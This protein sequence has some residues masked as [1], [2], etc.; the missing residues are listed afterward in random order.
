MIRSL[1]NGISGLRS[2]QTR[3]DV[4]SNNIANVNSIGFK[5]GR[6]T[7]VE[8][9]GQEMLGLGRTAGGSNINPGYIGQ[10]VSVGSVDQQW[11]QG[12]LQTTNFATD[13]ALHGDGFF[14]GSN[15]T[16]ELLT[17]D[18]H[19][20]FNEEGYLVTSGGIKIQ[21]W[22]IAE[23]GSVNMG[24]MQDVQINFDALAKPQETSNIS[25]GGNLAANTAIGEEITISTVLFDSQGERHSVLM[26]YTKTGT[27][28]WDVATELSDGTA[29]GTTAIEFDDEGNLINPDPPEL[30]LTGDYPDTTTPDDID[31]TI[32]LA[33]LKQYDGSTTAT[34]RSNDGRTTGDLLGYS[35]DPSGVLRVNF[36]NGD[37]TP[38]F[39]L[40]IGTVNN[41]N[42]L[43]QLGDNFYGVTDASGDLIAGRAGQ[44]IQTAIVA[45]ALEMS[46]VDLAE[47]F[48]DMII[49]QRGY[50]AS[51]RVITTSDEML[52]ETMQLKR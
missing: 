13:L 20:L 6:S 9:L 11:S 37:Q 10:G 34:V 51:A 14:I 4:I 24:K 29:L 41:P 31:V 42:G 17:R 45:G 25:I 40:A 44:E 50:Q 12:A 2:H 49:A 1:H 15:G 28:T 32:S 7:F 23:D 43:E 19:L 52:Q 22:D 47:E 35:I 16:R 36:S 18:G 8:V 27:N 21:G 30:A 3:M 38:S 33:N 26:K 39:Q 48:T 5:R 46:N